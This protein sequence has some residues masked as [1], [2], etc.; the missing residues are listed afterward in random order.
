MLLFCFIYLFIFFLFSSSLAGHFEI[1]EHFFYLKIS[2]G[3]YSK[4]KNI[5][6][7][8]LHISTLQMNHVFMTFDGSLEPCLRF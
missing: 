2:S 3:F 5:S 1:T 8:S 6:D 7:I 4:I